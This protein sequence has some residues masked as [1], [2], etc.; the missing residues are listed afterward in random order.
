MLEWHRREDKAF[1]WEYYRIRDLMPDAMVEERHCL[2]GLEL[3]DDTGRILR[4]ALHAYRFPRQETSIQEGATLRTFEFDSEPEV[5]GQV[6]EVDSVSGTIAVKKTRKTEGLHARTVFTHDFVPSGPLRAALLR[7]GD[8]VAEHGVDAEGA[9]RAGRDLLLSRP[10]QRTGQ[11]DLQTPGEL[12][13]D[14][15]KRLGL[16]LD[17]GVLPVQGPPGSG[18]TWTGVRMIVALVQAGRKVGITAVSHKVIQNLLKSVIEAAE[19]ERVEVACIQKVNEVDDDAPYG[20]NVVVR[21]LM[22]RVAVV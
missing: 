21:P 10:P 12:P 2:S 16:E 4:S 1:W 7:F 6:I 5:F 8:W 20:V 18:K 17:H 15:A 11:G 19:A 14:A 3:V 13:L 22:V 9:W